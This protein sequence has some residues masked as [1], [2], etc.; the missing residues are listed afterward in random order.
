ESAL[1]QAETLAEPGEV[2]ILAPGCASFDEFVNYEAR[3]DRFRELV[4][5]GG[6]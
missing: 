5:R 3:G 6:E 2:V 1:R 4:K